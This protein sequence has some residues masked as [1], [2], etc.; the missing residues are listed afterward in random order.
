MQGAPFWKHFLAQMHGFGRISHGLLQDH[1]FFFFFFFPRT[2]LVQRNVTLVAQHDLV[3][4]HR[5]SVEAHGA[6][7]IVGVVVC[8]FDLLLFVLQVVWVRAT[9]CRNSPRRGQC[10]LRVGACGIRQ[11]DVASAFSSLVGLAIRKLVGTK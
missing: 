9:L 8:S 6:C 3:L 5:I 10:S 1:F 7:H 2:D 11:T 4:V